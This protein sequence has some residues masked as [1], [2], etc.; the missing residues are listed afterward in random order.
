MDDGAVWLILFILALLGIAITFWPITLAIAAGWIII[1]FSKKEEKR[2]ALIKAELEKKL[3]LEAKQTQEEN[4]RLAAEKIKAERRE[5]LR[6]QMTHSINCPECDGSGMCY[7]VKVILEHSDG[8][9]EDPDPRNEKGNY[10]TP[11]EFKS[12]RAVI[13]GDDTGGRTENSWSTTYYDKKC[14]PFCGG[15]GKAFAYF[16]TN[17]IECHACLGTKQVQK[18]RKAEIGTEAFWV[19][20]EECKGAGVLKNKMVYFMYLHEVPGRH[21]GGSCLLEDLYS[22]NSIVLS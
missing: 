10:I 8:S 7:S 2:R 9:R 17:S 15:E 6:N 12:L 3:Q 16:A 14:C 11:H 1:H 4:N 18:R 13:D 22:K 21:L 5:K 20:C 19:E